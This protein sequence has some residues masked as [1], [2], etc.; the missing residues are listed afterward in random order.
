M[1]RTNRPLRH[2]FKTSLLFGA[3]KNPMLMKSTADAI[4]R[5]NQSMLDAMQ[6]RKDAT[7]APSEAKASGCPIHAPLAR[8]LVDNGE[9]EDVMRD[10][11]TTFAFAGHDTTANLMTWL[12]FEVCQVPRYLAQ[13]R[14]EVDRAM[15]QCGGELGFQ[16]LLELPFLSS[17]ITETLR[18]WPSVPNG[19]FRELQYD[20]SFTTADG[21]SIMAPQG[22]QVMI[23]VW[24]LHMNPELWGVDAHLFNPERE[25]RPE[26]RYDRLDKAGNPQSHRYAPFAFTPR[27][28]IG[29][30]FA[31]MEA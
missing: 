14:A 13:L 27:D 31:Q 24:N 6:A 11:T 26:E 10:T 9:D 16:D 25:W 8:R 12:V 1:E 2:H 4:K 23:P 17:C 21:S 30:N 28:C 3:G 5:V 18:L 15:A 7:A 22:T 19:T 20:E 29:K